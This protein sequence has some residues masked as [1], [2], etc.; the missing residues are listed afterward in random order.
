ML[1]SIEICAGAGGQALG[2]EM[3]GFQH[4][5]LVEYEKDYCETLKKNRP[6]WNIICGDVREFSGLPCPPFSVAGKQLG[7]EDAAEMLRVL[8]DGRRLKDISDL[9]LDLAT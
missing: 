7:A 5:A 6:A 8:I 1:S 4:A 2:L 3:A 9:P